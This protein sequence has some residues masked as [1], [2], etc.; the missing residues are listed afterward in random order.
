MRNIRELPPADSD[1]NVDTFAGLVES[2]ES[3]PIPE[4][5]LSEVAP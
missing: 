1:S 5:P 2:E 4:A 3:P